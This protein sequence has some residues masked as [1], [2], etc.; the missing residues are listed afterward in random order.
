V[1]IDASTSCRLAPVASVNCRHEGT[2]YRNDAKQYAVYL[3]RKRRI[4][5]TR[6]AVAA[7]LL[8]LVLCCGLISVL[9][10]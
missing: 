8:L 10:R 7:T 5:F 4:S 9:R 2:R 6:L 3:R 1:S